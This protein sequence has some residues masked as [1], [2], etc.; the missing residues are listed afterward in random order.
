MLVHIR[1][2]S[3]V[4]SVSVVHCREF[5]KKTLVYTATFALLSGPWVSAQRAAAQDSVA[6]GAAKVAADL[7]REKLAQTLAL[8]PATIEVVSSE[9]TTWPDSGLGCA[10]PGARALQ[11]VTA[12][13]ALQLRS[14]RGVHSVHAT[15]KYAV[16]C[17]AT[18]WGNPPRVGTAEKSQ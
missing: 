16:V 17:A 7:A 13:Y 8:D 5:M 11:V 15:E 1:E 6:P 9:P 3:R 4:I 18:P 14:P 2:V 12:G 10:K